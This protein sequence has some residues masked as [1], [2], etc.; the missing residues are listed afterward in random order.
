MPAYFKANYPATR[1]IIHC[2]DN[3]CLLQGQLPCY[4]YHYSLHRQC[5]LASRLTTLLLVSLF[6]AQTMPACF[7]ANYPATCIIIHCTDNA[8]LL[9]GQLP[10]YSYHYSLHRQC[11][12]ASRPT[13][14]LLVSLFIAQTM[15]ACFKANYPATCIIIHCT[16]NACLL[17]GQ[18][19]CYSYHYSLHRQC[20]LASRPTTL[21]LVSLLIAQTMPAYF[22]ANYPATCIIIDCTDNACLL[23][24]QLPCYLYHY[25]LHRQCLLASRPTTLLLVSLLI[26]QTMPAYF[27]ANY[28]ATCIII[29]CTDNACLL[30]GQLPCYSHHYSLHRQCLLASRPTTL[31]LV[32]LLIAQTM[33]AY[34]KANYPATCIIIH[35][36]DNACLLQGQLPCY[37]YHY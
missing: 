36:T 7:K 2:T 6:I 35:C 3:A 21:L 8:C 24:G 37:L 22:K 14:L 18:L 10:C 9:Q 29:H 15:P 4:L 28:P 27:K 31:L 16:D 17:Q 13:T 12:L 23:Q 32:S 25:S 19:P 1:I 11:L 20:L 34:F 33:P 5:L 26:A 30:Q